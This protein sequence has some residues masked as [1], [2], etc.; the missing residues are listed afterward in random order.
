MTTSPVWRLLRRNISPGQ[1]IG[2]A[3]ANLV[4]L[5]IVLTA[6][7]FYNDVHTA[8]TSDDSMLRRDY[9]VVSRQVGIT[10]R[11]VAFS[12]GDLDDIESQPWVEAIGR[13]EPST[14][15]ANIGVEF[16]GHGMSTETFFESIPDRFFDHLPDDWT[17][18]PQHGEVPIILSRDYL[19][20]YNFGFASTRGLPKFREGEVSMVPLTITL[21][22]N[23]RTARL[24]GHI[25]GFSSRIS[26]I[27]VPQEFMTWANS[28]FGDP[29]AVRAPSRLVVEVNDPGNPA[30]RDYMA[31]NSLEIAGDKM[32]NSEASY[33]LSVLTAVVIGV[34]AVISLLA[35]MILMLSI[36]LLLQKSR[37]KLRDLMLLGYTPQRVSV[38]Y[39]RMVAAVNLMVIV[40][41][42]PAVFIA[43]AYWRGAIASL[44]LPVGPVWPMLATA[45]TVI[46]LITTLNVMTIRRLVRRSVAS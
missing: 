4:G 45:L 22:G 16:Q 9:L 12:A 35:F 39:Y 25:A 46:L 3:V 41:A 27:A 11:N 40:L 43:R 7:Q 23:G 17:F 20:L 19:S 15:K 2:Y 24:R 1:I 44:D 42:I 5:V 14:F 31:R 32:D 38:Y 28:T 33:I 26:T 6:I 37:D 30:I 36:Y 13:F 10:D 8:M 21:S 34:G 29:D 18:D